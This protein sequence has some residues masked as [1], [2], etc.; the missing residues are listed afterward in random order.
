M[1]TVRWET[2]VGVSITG[3]SAQYVN[4]AYAPAVGSLQYGGT[5]TDG[6][7]SYA[8]FFTIGSGSL[9]DEG[10]SWT[11]NTEL[12]FFRVPYVNTGSSCVTFEVLDDTYQNT[13]NL[14]WFIS[15]NALDKTDGYISGET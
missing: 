9:F 4:P 12:P 11:A 15:L 3:A 8:T 1:I 2:T 10:L 6:L 7:Y 13:N 14:Q 5:T